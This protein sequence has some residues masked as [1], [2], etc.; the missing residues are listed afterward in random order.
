M[1]KATRGQLEARKNKREKFRPSRMQFRLWVR[2]YIKA[3]NY[4]RRVLQ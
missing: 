4:E 1:Q 3:Y 2:D